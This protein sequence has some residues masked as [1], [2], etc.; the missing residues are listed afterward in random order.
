M[1][2][3]RIQSADGRT[4]AH[5]VAAPWPSR[6]LPIFLALALA[7]VAL[8]ARPEGLDPDREIAPFVRDLSARHRFEPA[9]LERIL[10]AAS[11]QPQVI[12]AMSRQAESLD[13]HQYRPIF[14][15]PERVS[16][17]TAFWRRHRETL[18]RAAKE[19]GVAPSVI[20][21]II[22]VETR[23]GKRMGT[24]SVLDSLA[25]LAFRFP[26]RAEF[27]RNEL[28]AYLLLAR[29]EGIDPIGTN[30]SFA[31]ALGIP[32]FIPSSYRRY[33]VDFDGDNVRDL[34]NSPDDA[35]GSVANYL[36]RHG[37]KAGEGIAL[38]AAVSGEEY[39]PLL[40][41]GSR[42]HTVL[43]DM[44]SFGVVA[45]GASG[46]AE[47]GALIELDNSDG[48]EHWIGLQNFYAITR[49]NHSNLYAMAVFQLAREI[50]Q[51]Y[52]GGDG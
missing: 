50:E 39:R 12:E 24:H 6:G 13:W 19:F 52:R 30:G 47:L 1:S 35:I 40:A 32:Q 29:D 38:P 8:P 17:G 3:T 27:F 43:S 14:V 33:A 42:P 34:I 18:D 22:G 7:V 36:D 31:G 49:Y 37:W 2:F 46:S 16:E 26:R 51:N 21:A 45:V 9:E 15:T 20:V 10:L 4:A 44:A 28:E 48:P 23:Y 5:C 25:T 11:I 41:K